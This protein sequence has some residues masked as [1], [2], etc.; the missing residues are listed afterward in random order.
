MKKLQLKNN[1]NR[2]CDILCAKHIFGSGLQIIYFENI[3]FCF[4][5]NKTV[6]FRKNIRF[7]ALAKKPIPTVLYA[8]IFHGSQCSYIHDILYLEN[9]VGCDYNEQD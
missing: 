2:T 4:S 7:L 9:E 3:I 5:T 6:F 1:P 8:Y